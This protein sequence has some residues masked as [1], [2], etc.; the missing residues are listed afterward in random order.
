M[1]VVPYPL[2]MSQEPP[3]KVAPS[4]PPPPTSLEGNATP[5]AQFE[6]TYQEAYHLVDR[7]IT[8][9]TEGH[10]AQVRSVLNYD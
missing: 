10:N 1:T 3:K 5:E 9:I 8:L 4:R 7:G 2:Q 6:A